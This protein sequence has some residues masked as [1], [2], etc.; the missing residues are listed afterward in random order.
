MIIL[1]I[2][3]FIFFT[4]LAAWY[5]TLMDLIVPLDCLSVWGYEW[6]YAA[7]VAPKVG[8]WNKTL[9]PDKWHRSKIK[10]LLCFGVATAC[11]GL[12]VALSGL[13]VEYIGLV[14]IIQPLIASTAFNIM[15]NLMRKKYPNMR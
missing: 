2:I 1:T 9:P 10:R 4:I 15:F 12:F 13:R 7:M 14:F 6:S 11:Y 3:G 8:W 5:N